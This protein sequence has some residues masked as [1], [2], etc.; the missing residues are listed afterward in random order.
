MR[1]PGQEQVQEPGQEQV[2]EQVPVSEQE[3]EQERL[4]EPG[5]AAGE[6]SGLPPCR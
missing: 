4:P 5:K 2:Q 3:Q 1:L 6:C